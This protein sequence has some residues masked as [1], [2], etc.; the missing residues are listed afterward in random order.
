MYDLEFYKEELR[1]FYID[2]YKDLPGAIFEQEMKMLEEIKSGAY[3][4]NFLEAFNERFNNMEDG[5]A[6]QRVIDIMFQK[7]E[8]DK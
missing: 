7:N 6:S 8:I 1:G 3:D 5:H 2:V 4:Y